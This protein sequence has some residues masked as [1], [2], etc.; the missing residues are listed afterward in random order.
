[1]V[2]VDSDKV[3]CGGIRAMTVAVLVTTV[4]FVCK[5]I[6][7]FFLK[8]FFSQYARPIFICYQHTSGTK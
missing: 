4:L 8:L 7:I 6:N 2:T 3:V 5:S 1:M